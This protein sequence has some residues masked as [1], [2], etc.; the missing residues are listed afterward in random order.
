MTE[1]NRAYCPLCKNNLS[2]VDGFGFFICKFR[3]F[4]VNIDGEEK[5]GSGDV[6]NEDYFEFLNGNLE[7]WR[8]LMVQV[9]SRKEDL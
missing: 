4:G 1:K 2:V 9:D 3:F 8:N 7:N 5:E 6:G